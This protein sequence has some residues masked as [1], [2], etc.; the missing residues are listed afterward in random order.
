[1]SRSLSAPG[2]TS[3]DHPK[4]KEGRITKALDVLLGLTLLAMLILMLAEIIARSFLQSSTLIADEYSA[5]GLVIVGFLGL[6]RALST[7]SHVR[8]GALLAALSK[9]TR[10]RQALEIFSGLALFIFALIGFLELGAMMLESWERGTTAPTIARTPIYIPQAIATVGFALL[11]SAAIRYTI[12]AFR[13][14]WATLDDEI[15]EGD[16]L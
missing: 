15:T 5:Y 16:A 6:G 10:I 9:R 4:P 3:R 13:G 8:V 12:R 11:G 14:Q 7:G 2:L 1:M